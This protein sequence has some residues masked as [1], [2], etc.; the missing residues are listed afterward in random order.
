MAGPSLSR[1]HALLG[2]AAVPA[3]AGA[4][5]AGAAQGVL[6]RL[7]GPRAKTFQLEVTH[8]DEPVYAYEARGGRVTVTGSTP[9]A[10]VRGAYA[11]LGDLGLAHTSWEGQRIALPPRL[12][13]ARSGPVTSPFQ[14]RVY[15][16]TCTF[17]YTTP[18]WDWPRWRREIDWMALHGIDMPLAM[19]GQEWVWRALWQEEGLSP[20]ELD[21]YFSGPAF[22]PWQR[23]GNIEGYQAPLPLS[24][25]VKK[26]D[27]QK[28]ILGAMRELG[29]E[30]I[31]PAFAGYVPKAFAERHQD[32]RIYRMRAWEGFH[33]TYWL[34]PADPLF[35]R[36][37]TRFL[38]LYDATYGKGRYY[39]ADAFNEMLPPIG[40]GPQGGGY[41]DST[42]NKEEAAHVDPA[43]KAG[44]LAGYGKLLHDSIRVAR[45][46]A[47]WVMQGWLFGADQAFWT[48]DAVAAFLRDV[49]DD[50]LMVLDIGND[51]YPQVKKT[52][53]A[54]HGK[55]WIYGYVH[56]YGASNP[57]YGDLGFYQRDIA[58][59]T[60]APDRG[61]LQGFGVFPEGLDCNSI[62]YG[63]LYDLAWGPERSQ[64]A[65]LA[66]YTRARYGFSAP[67]MVTA[68][69]DIVK[70]A[71]ATRYW[72]PRW[73]RSTAGA[74]LLCKRPDVAMAEFEGAPGDRAA[75]RAGLT[76]LSQLAAGRDSLLLRHDLIELTRHLASLHLDDLIRDTLI[77]YR[78]GDRVAG[79]TAAL[80]V[81][82]L[83]LSL[84]DLM[85][86]QPWHLAGW[87][88]QA[89]SLGDTP[90]EKAYYER[91]ARAQVTVWGGKGN[92][93]DYASKAWQGLYRD[94]YLPRWLR[95]FDALRAGAFDQAAFTETLIAWEN[96]WVDST[97]P[98]VHRR[99]SDPVGDAARLLA[100]L[101]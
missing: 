69:Q 13:D 2:L 73:W 39:L 32:A 93:H 80:Q 43:V 35:A 52:A 90:A 96:A 5:P 20:A 75:L 49:P 7:I 54:F 15:M 57:V 70:G 100:G 79:D 38:D 53:E 10:T 74:Y 41:G 31:L 1:R 85:G 26:R 101:T 4:R 29:M 11:Y 6:Q 44:R 9:I 37:A 28:R 77:A 19:E 56:N 8:A 98:V 16:N 64:S 88:A 42:A 50:G 89:R 36:L 3:V 25:I 81:K 46:E 55:G 21:A 63:R 97:E 67:E 22:A 87:I 48:A 30:P 84:D 72:T 59:I 23:M 47:V 12:P 45:P 51:R 17:G 94:F 24:Y 66:T 91:N 68:W 92:L 71:Y 27:L 82:A 40:D 76:R 33:E 60:A 34:D 83:T 99:P 95:L 18:F 65:W 78:S 62:V 58:A 14:H 61:R 86:T